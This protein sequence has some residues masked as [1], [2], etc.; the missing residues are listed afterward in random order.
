MRRLLIPLAALAALLS[1]PAV[2]LGQGAETRGSTLQNP[3]NATFGCESVVEQDIFTIG[4]YF[5]SPQGLPSCTWFGQIPVNQPVTSPLSSAVAASGVITNVRVRSGPNPAPLRIS[6]L[7]SVGNP[8]RLPGADPGAGGGE[9]GGGCCFGVRESAVFQP[10]PNAVTQVTVNLPVESVANPNTGTRSYDLVAVS[11]AGGTG[12]LPIFDAGP[13]AHTFGALLAGAPWSSMTAPAFAPDN[14]PRLNMRAAPGWELLLQYDFVPVGGN[15]P[16][17]PQG[18]VGGTGGAG[19]AGSAGV[20][21]NGGAGADRLRGTAGPDRLSGRGGADVLR[22]LAGGDRLAG[23]PGA[24]SLLG[25]PGGDTL[26]GG[27]GADALDGGP[28]AD[29]MLARDGVRE[30][31]VCG[32]GRDRATLDR[33]DVAVGCEVVSRG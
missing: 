13:N 16:V 26:D 17:P 2:V 23:G 25:G 1:L 12:T 24:D 7:R 21:R 10:T 11:A 22:G 14:S 9:T 18:G 15:T 3:A 27:P 31:V 4:A 20:T 6:I 19:G 8:P 29:V 5:M 32:R 33:R 28:G 30:T